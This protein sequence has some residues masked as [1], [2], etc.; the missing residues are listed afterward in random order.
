MVQHAVAHSQCPPAGR[1]FCSSSESPALAVQCRFSVEPFGQRRSRTEQWPP[2][3]WPRRRPSW[4]S[5][6]SLQTFSLSSSLVLFKSDSYAQSTFV[7]SVEAPPG[8][9]VEWVAGCI[10]NLLSTSRDISGMGFSKT[11]FQC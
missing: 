4:D 9:D 10:H 6:S 7:N 8:E 1:V 11:L 2:E 3:C 5:C